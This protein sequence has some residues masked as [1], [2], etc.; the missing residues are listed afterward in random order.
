VASSRDAF[1]WRRH[2]G[3]I[4]QTFPE[5]PMNHRTLSCFALFLCAATAGAQERRSAGGAPPEPREV[6]APNARFP[7]A[8]SWIGIMNLRIDTIPL[9]VD[10]T[11]DNGRY[12]SVSYGPGGGRMNHL[13]TQL[14]GD[15]LRWEIK[16]SG[17]GVWI[18]EA[19]RIVGD[20]I[21]G[22]VKL[23]GMMGRDGTPAVGTLLLVRQR[24]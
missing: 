13:R 20:T 3:I 2:E 24:R 17:D 14:A 16:N 12:S 11:V 19:Q 15:A 23:E 9:A 5:T 7:F 10:I 6:I 18:Y 1:A 4:G 21:H 22:T 8:G